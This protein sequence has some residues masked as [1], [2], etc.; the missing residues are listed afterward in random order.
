[1]SALL[2]ADE[3]HNHHRACDCVTF[4]NNNGKLKVIYIDLKSGSPK[5]YANQFKSTRQFVNYLI[6]LA[7][8]FNPDYA[9]SI[10]EEIFLILWGGI[11][12]NM[13]KTTTIPV[14][15]A[16]EGKLPELPY[17]HPILNGAV[18]HLKQFI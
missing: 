15:K 18:V 11:K 6:G 16:K 9:M 13:P 12:I 4:I 1:M 7:N 5:G 17:K 10:E 3:N 2:I 8:E 14:K